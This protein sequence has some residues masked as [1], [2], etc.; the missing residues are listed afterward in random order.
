MSIHVFAGD[1]NEQ[2][3]GDYLTRVDHRIGDDRCSNGTKIR[4][5]FEYVGEGQHYFV[6]SCPRTASGGMLRRMT[7]C[8]ATFAKTGAA[9]SE[10]QM[11][12]LG[13]SSQIYTMNCGS[14]VG[15]QPTNETFVWDAS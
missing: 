1:R 9:V 4:Q 7:V 10:A 15:P 12:V 5:G 2:R 8:S 13:F 14:S 11:D 3:T 6:T